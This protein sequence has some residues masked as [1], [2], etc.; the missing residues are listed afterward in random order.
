M[1]A[2]CGY[3]YAQCLKKKVQKGRCVDMKNEL[4]K[5]LGQIKDLRGCLEAEVRIFKVRDWS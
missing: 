4:V 5:A 2:L 1:F 3:S